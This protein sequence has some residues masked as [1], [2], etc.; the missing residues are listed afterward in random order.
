MTDVAS[1]PNTAKL[2]AL[3]L[4]YNRVAQA[5]TQMSAGANAAMSSADTS[6]MAQM[7][8]ACNAMWTNMQSWYPK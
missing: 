5:A 6:T 8:N 1:D 7:I 3:I 2:T 4:F